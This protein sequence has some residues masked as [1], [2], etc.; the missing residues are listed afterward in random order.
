MRVI[1]PLTITDAML[2]SSTAAEPGVG[3]TAWVSGTTYAVGDVRILT[4]THRKYYRNNAGAGTTAPNLDTVNWTDIGPTNKWAMFDLLRNTATELASPLTI[5]L[6][7]GQRVGSIGLVGLQASSVTISVNVGATNH[8]L[9]TVSTIRRATTNWTSFFFGTFRYVQAF[10]LFDLPLITG[11]TITITITGTTCK[12]GGVVIGNSVYIGGAEY[13]ATRGALN[14]S[15]VTRDAFGNATLVQ[16]R[17]VPTINVKLFIDKALANSILQL[18]TDLNAVPALWSG[19]DDQ[20]DDGYFD[21]LLLLGVY[22]ELSVSLDH[23]TS[24]VVS[25]Q[26][27]EI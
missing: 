21:A 11:A 25:A 23:P 15:T 10:V 14:F 6:T 27:E 24:A 16:R 17:S 5:V 26:L 9:R 19:L 12:C 20:T 8:Y 2:T 18:I 3:E 13:G 22:K 7:P 4:S 1:P